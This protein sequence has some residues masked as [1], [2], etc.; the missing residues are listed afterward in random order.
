MPMSVEDLLSLDPDEEDMLLT[1]GL[2]D[3]SS[4]HLRALTNKE[5]DKLIESPEKNTQ[6]NSSKK[7]N[8]TICGLGTTSPQE[9]NCDSV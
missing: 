1:E 5:I 6:S 8:L 3:A 4:G 9:C 7:I 2:S